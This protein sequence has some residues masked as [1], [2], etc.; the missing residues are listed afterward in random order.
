MSDS[1]RDTRQRAP[2]PTPVPGEARPRAVVVLDLDPRV[3]AVVVSALTAEGYRA[4]G[5]A[6]P[7][8]AAHAARA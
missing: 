1:R 8:A 3:R 6:D 5:T 2:E 7:P 4:T